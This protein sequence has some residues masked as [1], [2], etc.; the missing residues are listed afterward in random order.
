MN[1]VVRPKQTKILNTYGYILGLAGYNVKL[2]VE[3]VPMIIGTDAEDPA[4]E[5]DITNI[6]ND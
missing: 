6:A 3:P 4:V 1:T 2:E 5:E